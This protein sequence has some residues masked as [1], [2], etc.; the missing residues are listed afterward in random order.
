MERRYSTDLQ[1]VRLSFCHNNSKSIAPE[2]KHAHQEAQTRDSSSDSLGKLKLFHARSH[3]LAVQCRVSMLTL[4]FVLD[5]F[6]RFSAE[7]H[8]RPGA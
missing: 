8:V 1:S 3:F 7:I 6:A 2:T 5:Q 4:F